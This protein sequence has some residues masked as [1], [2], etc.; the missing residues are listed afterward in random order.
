MEMDVEVSTDYLAKL[1]NNLS[2]EIVR[3]C[4]KNHNRTINS[5]SMAIVKEEA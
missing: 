1:A 2:M 5:E 4:F 3:N